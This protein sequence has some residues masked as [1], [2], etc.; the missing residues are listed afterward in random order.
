MPRAPSRDGFTRDI[1]NEG[2]SIVKELTGGDPVAIERKGR[3][4]IT[5]RVNAAV[6]L[7]SNYRLEFVQGG[8]DVIS[9]QDRLI[10]IPFEQSIPEEMQVKDIEEWFR[11]E[12]SAIAYH[13][14]AAYN[15]VEERGTITWVLRNAPGQGPVG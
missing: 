2:L 13:A 4:P 10:I 14:V 11:P 9:W 5:A 1:Y 6:W 12:L 8:E 3:D 7:D 15:L